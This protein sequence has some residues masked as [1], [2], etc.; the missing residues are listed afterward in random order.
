MTEDLSKFV[1]LLDIA[2]DKISC[3]LTELTAA[4]QQKEQKEKMSTKSAF[5][6]ELIGHKWTIVRRSPSSF[7]GSSF[8]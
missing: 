7:H 2:A 1:D 3:T 4:K 8:L 5:K 6:T